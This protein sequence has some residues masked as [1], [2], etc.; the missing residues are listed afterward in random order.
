MTTQKNEGLLFDLRTLERRNALK[1]FAGAALSI[2]LLSA[3]GATT[4]GNSTCGVI[5][6][7]TGGPYPGDGS[8]GV[9]TLTQTGIVRNDIRSSFGTYSGTAAGI[10]LT[11][12][13]T[14]ID[15]ANA[16]APLASHAIYLWHA[17]KDGKYSLYTDANQNYLRG[18]QETDSAGKVSF[19][20]IFP[21]CYDGRF[22]H[23]HFE[24][25]KSLAVATGSSGVTKTSQL[26]LPTDAC[27]AVY[28]T[29]GYET[30]VSN[31]AKTSLTSDMVFSDG[32]TLQVATITG[33]TTDGYVASLTIGI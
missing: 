33:N 1:L 9:N 28:A 22:P 12:Q 7:E 25:F 8:N 32:S 27:K 3:C 29:T 2:P 5:P 15:S 6:T 13:L 17:T 20:T 31:L 30:S 4:S 19:K 10:P 11:I 18:V 14:L 16:C 24:I 26:A 23:V 21:G